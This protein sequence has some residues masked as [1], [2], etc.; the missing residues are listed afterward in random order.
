MAESIQTVIT[1]HILAQS[2]LLD[3]GVS[4]LSPLSTRKV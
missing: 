3:F 4:E 1:N 2:C